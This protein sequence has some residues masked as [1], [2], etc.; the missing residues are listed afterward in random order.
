MPTTVDSLCKQYKNVLLVEGQDDLHVV[1]QLYAK[2]YGTPL[3]PD[4]FCIRNMGGDANLLAGMNYEIR[5]RNRG[6]VGVI[7]DADRADET[8]Q[9][10]DGSS[11]RWKM[12]A[13]Q[14]G[15]FGITDLQ[16]GQAGGIIIPGKPDGAPRLPDIGVPPRIGVW[17]MPDNQASGELED[18]I[19][20]MIPPGITARLLAKDYIDRVLNEISPDDDKGRLQERKRLR[21]EIHAWLATR[22]QPRH[23]GA[24]IEADYLNIDG[25]LCRSF[26]AWLRRLFG[27][28]R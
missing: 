14:L 25:E 10:G 6:I 3:V 27:E 4:V 7:V 1:L 16:T 18:F 28:P 21:G 23:M 26:M 5:N 8:D 13:D 9:A 19:N 15:A 17:V 2:T 24:A 11:R 12:V 20:K 22:R